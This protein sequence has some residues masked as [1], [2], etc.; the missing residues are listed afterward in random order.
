MSS[1]LLIWGYPINHLDMFESRKIPVV[2]GAVGVSE[3]FNPKK[4]HPDFDYPW[5]GTTPGQPILPMPDEVVICL[6]RRFKSVEFDFVPYVHFLLLSGRLLEFLMQHGLTVEHGKS[7]AVI[8]DVKGSP[9]TDEE[10]YFVRHVNHLTEQGIEWVRDDSGQIIAARALPGAERKVFVPT[11]D[12]VIE[13]KDLAPYKVLLVAEDLR[14]E[15]EQRFRN[16]ALYTIPEWREHNE[17]SL[18]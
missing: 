13:A 7:R 6:M 2:S 4:T 14:S 15:I 16:P 5:V 12:D 8:V 3:V 9:L 1:E 17:Y 11:L 10:F 18:F